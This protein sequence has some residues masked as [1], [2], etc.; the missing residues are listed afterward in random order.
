M[1]LEGLS[2]IKVSDDT[3][4]KPFDCG[5]EDLNDFLFN[6]AKNYHKELLATTFV[7]EDTANTVAYYSIFNDSL[8]VEEFDFASKSAFKRFLQ[9]LTSH[10]KR[11]L[12]YFPAIKTGRLAVNQ[13]IKKSGFGKMIINHIIDF[14]LNLNEECACKLITVDAYEQSLSFYAKMGFSYLSENDKGKN[15][16]QMYLDLMPLINTMSSI[17]EDN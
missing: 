6:K 1:N 11:H 10:P 15:T 5:D 8:R 16:R 3:L 4:I 13:N 12:R 17:Q 9:Q 14:A 2:L 7:I